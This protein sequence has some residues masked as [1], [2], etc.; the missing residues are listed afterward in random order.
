MSTGKSRTARFR[1]LRLIIFILLV[2]CSLYLF[3]DYHG[4]VEIVLRPSNILGFEGFRAKEL[5]VQGFDEHE[6][7][8]AIRGM[9]IYK[10]KKGEDRFKKIAHVPT[11]FSIFWF[12]NFSLVRKFTLRPECME[13]LVRKSGEII[14][15]SAGK[16][17][18]LPPGSDSF[19]ETLALR[20]Y[21][22]GDQGI[23][24]NGITIINDSTVC[25]G[26]YFR[27]EDREQVDVYV[28]TDN[29]RHWKINY[30][31]KPGEVRH[32]HSL[33]KDPFENKMW[34]TT[35]DVKKEPRIAWTDDNY[36]TIHEIGG[37]SQLW[38]ATQLVFDQDYLYWGADTYNPK[39][40][41]L[42]RWSRKTGEVEKIADVH[43]VIFHSTMLKDGTIV[44]TTNRE[45]GPNEKDK[46]TRMFIIEKDK[47]VR[48]LNVGTWFSHKPG[49]WFKYA[50]LRLQRNQGASMLAMSCLSQKEFSNGE[51]LLIPEEALRMGE[52][53]VNR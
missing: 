16:L 20:H 52:E 43:G 45:G 15:M 28:S 30:S 18:H 13:V 7:L 24:D 42:Y 1:K 23:F 5:I 37:G 34:I 40:E 29:G 46:Q 33:Q 36:K 8:Y 9:N 17:W 4:P 12:R 49:F 35:G 48:C 11:G 41:G 2:G 21:Q 47:P 19:T 25:F 39:Y 50:K 38:R 22:K 3:A 10:L 51:L 31:F 26:E 44:M 53:L 14:A 27:N 6:N 32:I